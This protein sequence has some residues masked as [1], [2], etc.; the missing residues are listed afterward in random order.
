[1]RLA[2]DT[3]VLPG[4]TSSPVP[5]DREPVLRM[6]ADVVERIELLQHGEDSFVTSIL[7]RIPP[8]PPNHAL[9]V[10]LNEAGLVPELAD[11]IDLEAGANRCAVS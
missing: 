5:F 9:I 7:G 1:M 8:T 10:Q 3:I 4:H 6:L 2:P 11:T